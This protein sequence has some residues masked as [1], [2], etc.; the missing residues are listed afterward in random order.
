ML[1]TSQC[2]VQCLPSQLHQSPERD[3]RKRMKFH[4]KYV[5]RKLG[6]TVEDAIPVAELAS[7][8]GRLPD[9]AVDV[10]RC[11]EGYRHSFAWKTPRGEHEGW[12]TIYC[13]Y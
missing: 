10:I 13:S 3:R 7:K 11:P 1:L 6:L 9:G 5:A 8:L 4:A 2:G 12:I